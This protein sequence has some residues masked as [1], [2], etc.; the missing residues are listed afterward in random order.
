MTNFTEN[1]TVYNKKKFTEISIPSDSKIQYVKGTTVRLYKKTFT[2]GPG[3]YYTVPP[4]CV[5]KSKN[6]EILD[7]DLVD[8]LPSNNEFSCAVVLVSHKLFKNWNIWNYRWCWFRNSND[9]FYLVN[10]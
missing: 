3:N 5:I 8:E 4:N 1:T 9:N 7:I 6:K 10:Y 2:A